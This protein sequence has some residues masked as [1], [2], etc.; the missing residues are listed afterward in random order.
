MV[1]LGVHWGLLE[2]RAAIGDYQRDAARAFI[3]HGADLI[4]GH[5][6]LVTKWIEVYNGK[7][8]FYSLGKFLMKGPRPTGDVPIGVNAAVISEEHTSELQSLMRLSY[9]FFFFKNK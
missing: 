9:A 3:D 8:I 2:D 6:T 4:L 1:V 5:G 7:V